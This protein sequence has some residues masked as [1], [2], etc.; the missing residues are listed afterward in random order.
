[1]LGGP[2]RAPPETYPLTSGGR[3]PPEKIFLIRVHDLL[4]HFQI[5]RK[6]AFPTYPLISKPTF[7]FRG[8][9]FQNLKNP[10]RL[11]TLLDLKWTEKATATV[12][13]KV[14]I[15]PFIVRKCTTTKICKNS[16]CIII[17]SNISKFSLK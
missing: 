7:D 12:H 1:M 11:W 2:P 10:R 3:R 16:N 8:P 9:D 14:K 17:R 15:L 13:F 5:G 6:R 4:T